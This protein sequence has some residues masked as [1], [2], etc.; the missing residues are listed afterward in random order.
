MLNRNANYI[1]FS[2]VIDLGLTLFAV[3]AAFWLRLNLP[4]GRPLLSEWD[5]SLLY[6]EAALL[7][8]VVF[9]LFSLYDPERTFRAADEYQTLTV[10]CLLAGLALAGLVYFT[11]RDISRLALVYFYVVHFALLTSWRAVARLF[12]KRQYEQGIVA[13]RVL[14]IGG[15]DA[16]RHTLERLHEL[17]WNGVR[18]VGYL[19]DDPPIP[20]ADERVPNLGPLLRFESTIRSLQVDDVLLAL[21]TESYEKVQG[22][23]T[24]LIDKPCNVWIVPDYFNLFLYGS[25]VYNLGGIPLIGIKV[26]TLSGYQRVIKRAFDLCVGTL[27]LLPALPAMAIIALAIRL[28]S[29]GPFLLKQQRVGEN[30]CL[31]WMYKFRSMIA[32]AEEHLEEVFRYDEQGRLIHK[33][34]NDPRV[35]RVGRF[36][37]RMSLDEL[38]QLFNVLRGEMSLVGPRPEL[39]Y[40]VERYQPW[41][42]KRFA[43][44]Q[45]ITGWWQ[46][47]GRSDKPMHLY[48]ED[49]LFYIQHYSIWLDLQILLRTIWV[50]LCGRGA[51]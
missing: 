20:T 42:R 17:S 5:W 6:Y 10:A 35:T 46:V 29:R 4:W 49:D 48:T 8:P 21:P 30:G 25:S 2:F 27:L 15:G 9:F 12:Q 50:V 40:L 37:R 16:L 7:Y 32:D 11:N 3:A 38:P 44:P 28:D 13:R 33:T 45:G 14:I 51:Y 47:N 23:V 19:T 26:P 41:Q 1:L 43:V 24:Q 36:L 22:F 34:A 39:P 31:F 18:L